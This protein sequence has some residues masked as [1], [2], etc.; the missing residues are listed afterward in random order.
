MFGHVLGSRN[1]PDLTCP[2]KELLRSDNP[3]CPDRRLLALLDGHKLRPCTCRLTRCR[4]GPPKRAV[5]VPAAVNYSHPM[6]PLYPASE[7]DHTPAL[8]P[9][10]SQQSKTP[11]PQQRNT[12][13]PRH[14]HETCK[15][16][17]AQARRVGATT[18]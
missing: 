10:A 6:P 8:S 4:C 14:T 3:A 17:A 16:G 5:T 1:T 2:T 13:R 15:R 7:T 11:S 18:G 9:S 12:H